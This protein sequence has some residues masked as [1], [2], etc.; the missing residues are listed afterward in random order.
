MTCILQKIIKLAP[1]LNGNKE[2]LHE[3]ITEGKCEFE[4]LRGCLDF[5]VSEYKFKKEKPCC[6]SLSH[7]LSLLAERHRKSKPTLCID[8]HCWRDFLPGTTVCGERGRATQ[9]QFLGKRRSKHVHSLVFDK[10]GAR[11]NQATDSVQL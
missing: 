1:V 6:E 5:G 8:A 3:Y 7:T 2:P 10:S 9:G 11:S 4:H